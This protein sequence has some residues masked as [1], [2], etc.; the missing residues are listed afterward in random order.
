MIGTIR[1]FDE[2]VRSE[3]H[4]RVKRTAESIAQSAGARAEV[5]IELGYPVTVNN[6]ALTTRM[7]PT[8][9]RAAGAANVSPGTAS[10]ASEDFSR[11]AQKVPGLFV[12]LSVTPPAIDWR[13]AAPNHSPLF[14][15]DESALPVGVRMMSELAIDY[16]NGG[17]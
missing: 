1:T 12:F 8:L 16:L 2:S 14:Q 17:R 15:A 5:T 10:T 13:T 3:I 11:F 4:M 6:P 7:V 9:Q